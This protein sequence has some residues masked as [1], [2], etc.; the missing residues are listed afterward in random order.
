MTD[1]EWAAS[2]TKIG[3]FHSI[4]LFW[5]YW[6]NLPLSRLPSGSNVRFFK[7]GI[8][9]TWDDPNNMNGGKWVHC[10]LCIVQ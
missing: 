7:S 10:V 5:R 8:E 3:S 6:N 1:E 9:P 4:Q 2:V